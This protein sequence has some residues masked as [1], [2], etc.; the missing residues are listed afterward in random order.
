MYGDDNVAGV[1]YGKHKETSYILIFLAK[2]PEG[3]EGFA[4]SE[5]MALSANFYEVLKDGQAEETEVIANILKPDIV[6]R[7]GLAGL[8]SHREAKKV[9]GLIESTH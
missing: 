9:Y 7:D 8:T 4:S 3:A 5:F 2:E 1:R 6:Q